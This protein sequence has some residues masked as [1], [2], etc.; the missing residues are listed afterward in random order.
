MYSQ[1]NDRNKGVGTVMVRDC[2]VSTMTGTGGVDTVIVRDYTVSTM[3]GT[4]VV[5]VRDCTVSTM[6]GTQGKKLYRI[7]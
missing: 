3:T 6:T 7:L 1:Y 2:T 5:M 4:Q